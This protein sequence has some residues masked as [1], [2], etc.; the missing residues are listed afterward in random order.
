MASNEKPAKRKKQP[1]SDLFQSVLSKLDRID[2]RLSSIE[3]QQT[4]TAA[5]YQRQGIFL[6]EVNKRCMAK[7]GLKC[8]LEDN[9]EEGENENVLEDLVGQPKE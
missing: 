9:E 1:T 7:L 4:L 2:Q 8:S 6:E 5:A 3:T